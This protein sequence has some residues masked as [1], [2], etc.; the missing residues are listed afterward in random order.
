MIPW[1]LIEISLGDWRTAT[2]LLVIWGVI[3][4]FRRVAEPR[5][6]GSQ[7]GLHPVLSLL[8]IF[9]GMK[10][11]GVLGMILAPTILLVIL[12][13]CASGVFDGVVYDINLAFQDLTAFLRNQKPRDSHKDS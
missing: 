2:Y 3:A 13:V 5:F 6:L 11:F 8:S 4:L 12:C 10:A 9:V 7:T 1:A